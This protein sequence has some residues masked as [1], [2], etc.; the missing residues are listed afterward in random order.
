MARTLSPGEAFEY[1]APRQG[2]DC[3]DDGIKDNR[4]VGQNMTLE[5]WRG[6]L[7]GKKEGRGR[8]TIGHLLLKRQFSRRS[9]NHKS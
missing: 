7:T 8:P 6:G 3:R 5:Y 4:S 9:N 1:T 2:F